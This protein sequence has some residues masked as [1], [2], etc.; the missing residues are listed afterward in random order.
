[1]TITES[2]P[3]DVIRMELVFLRPFASTA[4]AEFSFK[5]EGAGTVVTWSMQGRNTFMGKAI[6]RSI[7][8]SPI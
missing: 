5:P 8:A 7:E 3:H 4:T 1:M 6:G 2:R